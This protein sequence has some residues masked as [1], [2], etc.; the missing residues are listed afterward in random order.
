MPSRNVIKQYSGNSYYHIYNRG[1][2]KRAIFLDKQDYGTFLSYLKEYLLPIDRDALIAELGREGITSREK[3]QILKKLNRNNYANEV[4]LIAYCL[5]PNHFHL[6]IKQ[7]NSNS[8]DGFMSSLSTRYSIYFNRR[9]TRI[10]SLFQGVY[11]AVLISTDEQ[12]LQLSRYIHQQA[13]RLQGETLEKTLENW[14]PSSCPEYLNQ[15]NSAWVK[16]NEILAYFSNNSKNLT[17][18]SFLGKKVLIEDRLMLEEEHDIPPGRVLGG[19]I[20]IFPR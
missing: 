19:T 14:T 1:V 16:P 18:E 3:D 2:E 5:M 17:Y 11:K 9:H 12:L 6:L 20:S 4:T 10:G 7:K 8:I 15:R 13:T